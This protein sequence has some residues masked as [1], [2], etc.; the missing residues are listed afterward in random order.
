MVKTIA[1]SESTWEK[2]KKIMEMEKASTFQEV[3]DRLIEKTSTIPKSMFGVNKQLK[4][5][6]TQEEHEEMTRDNHERT[7][8][9]EREN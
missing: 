2:L 7:S 6:F 4:L 5:R 1:V 3:I 9:S 8:A